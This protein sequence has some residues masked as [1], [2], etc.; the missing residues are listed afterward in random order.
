[1]V[2]ASKVCA[3]KTVII[4]NAVDVD[5]FR[6]SNESNRRSQGGDTVWTIGAVG[7]LTPEKDFNLFLEVARLIIKK[8]ENIRFVIGGTG[9]MHTRLL[10]A[11]QD[12]DFQGRV[13]FIGARSDV[14]NVLRTFD[15]FLFTSRIE[16]SGIAVLEALACSIP[17]VA[18][19][20]ELGAAATILETLPGVSVVKGRDAKAL[21]DVCLNLLEDPNQLNNM[22]RVGREY[23][24]NHNSIQKYVKSIDDLYQSLF[25]NY[26]IYKGGRRR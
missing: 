20:P 18:A 22:G 24:T 4:E 1:M 19:Q 15:L 2:Q 8:R 13:D 21:A 10:D 6:P 14:P 9:S 25:R 23:V 17:V 16:A 5:Y 7:R 11:A 26:S 3:K 12:P